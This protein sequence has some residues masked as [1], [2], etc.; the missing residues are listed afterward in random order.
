MKW[1]HACVWNSGEGAAGRTTVQAACADAA[2]QVANRLHPLLHGFKVH[3]RKRVNDTANRPHGKTRRTHARNS[4]TNR[5]RM[6]YRVNQTTGTAAAARQCLHL[7]QERKEREG[8]P[9]VSLHTTFS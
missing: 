7:T 9:H 2:R 1:D 5:Q 6:V 8:R 3:L 4:D